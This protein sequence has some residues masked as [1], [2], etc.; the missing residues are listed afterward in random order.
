MLQAQRHKARSSN[1]DFVTGFFDTDPQGQY[2]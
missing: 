1:Q 2:P